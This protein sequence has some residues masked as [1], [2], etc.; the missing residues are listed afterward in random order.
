MTDRRRGRLLIAG[1]SLGDPNF[2]RTIVYL[3]V[4]NPDGALGVVLNRPSDLGVADA[5]P[6]W[7]EVAAR[8]GVVFSGG[9]VE[10]DTVL[11]L[12]RVSEAME[13]PGW[14]EVAGT[15]GTVDLAMDPAA[16]M[17]GIEAARIYIGYSGWGAGQLDEELAGGAWFLV[18]AE[19]EDIFSP[20]PDHLWGEVLR[21]ENAR[22][23]MATRNPSW[24]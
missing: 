15:V 6:S 11:G 8:P 16:V 22:A 23:A 1:P 10:A 18:D 21:R 20:D 17:P 2:D 14:A 12:A 3:L 19:P 5:L 4:H 9:P 13:A 7:S 24:N